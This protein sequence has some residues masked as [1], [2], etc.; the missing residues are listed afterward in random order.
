MSDKVISKSTLNEFCQTLEE[1]SNT[2]NLEEKF[3][4]SIKT[5]RLKVHS[6]SESIPSN[7]LENEM[8][9]F[10]IPHLNK[11]LT[12]I[13]T[14]VKSNNSESDISSQALS[15]INSLSNH[16]KRNKN[17]KA[18][19][20]LRTTKNNR[21][22]NS[23][24]LFS[25]NTTNTTNNSNNHNPTGTEILTD[26]SSIREKLQKQKEKQQKN[27]SSANM[28]EKE[29]AG[30]IFGNNEV[31]N[32]TIPQVSNTNKP[33]N[34]NN[35]KIA[36]VGSNDTHKPPSYIQKVQTINDIQINKIKRS[37]KPKSKK[38]KP[39]K[40]KYG[41]YKPVD[42]FQKCQ[43][44][45]LIAGGKVGEDQLPKVLIRRG[46]EHQMKNIS[47]RFKKYPICHRFAKAFL[48]FQITC[49]PYGEWRLGQSIMLHLSNDEWKSLDLNNMLFMDPLETATFDIERYRQ[50]IN[51]EKSLLEESKYENNEDELIEIDMNQQM[52]IIME[53]NTARVK[54]GTEFEFI[55]DF[56]D[57]TVTIISKYLNCTL[58]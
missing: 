12:N 38:S 46:K 37:P 3:R 44:E 55:Y 58:P 10:N 49:K 19:A 16:A 39:T 53:H 2:H 45:T 34:R 13:A 14:F 30:Y 56:D 18:D 31:N 9:S 23:N 48:Y 21:I 26:F 28:S 22:Y 51:K 41:S 27:I 47:N 57:D 15:I 1:M 52:H 32:T 7:H 50:I 35:I 5:L 25:T 36:I 8:K 20:Y 54:I 40:Q 4:H 33:E 17:T 11:T 24:T 43:W 6:M 42:A 29:W